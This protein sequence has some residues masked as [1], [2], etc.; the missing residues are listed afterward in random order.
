MWTDFLESMTND[1]VSSSF[2]I[3]TFIL[4]LTYFFSKSSLNEIEG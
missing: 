1:L 4:Q 2:E 3:E